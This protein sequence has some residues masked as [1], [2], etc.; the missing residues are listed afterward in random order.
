MLQVST[1]YHAPDVY[2]MLEWIEG[3]GW[4]LHSSLAEAYGYEGHNHAY[5]VFLFSRS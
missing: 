5:H 2:E 3:C 1:N 4:Q